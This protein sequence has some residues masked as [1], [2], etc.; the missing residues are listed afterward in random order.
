MYTGLA[1][2]LRRSAHPH[3]KS[4][5]EA[6]E[7]R[8]QNISVRV[9]AA[10]HDKEIDLV[11]YR[12]VHRGQELRALVRKSVVRLDVQLDEAK[13]NLQ[14]DEYG[15]RE[16]DRVK[17]FVSSI[18]LLKGETATLKARPYELHIP[19]PSELVD[20]VSFSSNPE[21]NILAMDVYFWF[22]R[23]D[24]FVEDRTLSLLFYMKPGQI[25]GYPGGSTWFDDEFRA[26]VH[27][28]AREQGKVP[29]TNNP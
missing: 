23:V 18:L 6:M 9:F 11:E 15:Q 3:K 12:W 25:V 13:E 29:P 2:I 7:S 19:W 22:R 27:E 28:Q 1:F 8:A 4:H 16:I 26:W 14:L 5:L 17:G 21:M 24:A 20:G 10:Y